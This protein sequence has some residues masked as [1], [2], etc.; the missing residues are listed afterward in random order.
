MSTKKVLIICGIILTVTIV[1]EAL[2]AHDHVYFWWHGFIA[3][4]AIYG[5]LGCLAIIVVS[6]LLGKAFLQQK[7]D[8]YDKGE[9]NGGVDG[10]V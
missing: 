9:D 7:E 8:Y 4:D 2:F 5:A 3:F 6:K 10:D 1:L